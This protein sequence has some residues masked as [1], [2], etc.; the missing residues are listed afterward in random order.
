MKNEERLRNWSMSPDIIGS[1]HL[2]AALFGVPENE[3]ARM[4]IVGLSGSLNAASSK[5]FKLEKENELML[6]ELKK[7]RKYVEGREKW[8]K[9]YGFLSWFRLFKR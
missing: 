9:F 1:I 4:K 8:L 3:L 5:I 2:D 6:K 7:A